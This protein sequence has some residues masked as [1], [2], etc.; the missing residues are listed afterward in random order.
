MALM[1]QQ[2]GESCSTKPRVGALWRQRFVVGF[3]FV[4]LANACG[5]DDA[6]PRL[7]QSRGAEGDAGASPMGD[8]GTRIKVTNV[9]D[10]C[11]TRDHGCQ[12]EQAQCLEI[13]LSGAFYAAGY[14]TADC[15]SSFEC[16][17]NA[18]CP[19]GESELLAPDYDFRSTW[20]RKCF[21]SCTPDVP[22]SCRYGYACKSLAVAYD[23]PDAPAPLH[24]N[25]CIPSIPTFSWDAG[26]QDAATH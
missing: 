5:G 14:C 10:P 24:R 22:D 16:G 12:G 11:L 7:Q 23:A 2:T 8:A 20:A 1:L 17:P 4:A 25:V 26:V 21:K 9:G 18:E 13:S 6:D 19:V 3:L 15:K